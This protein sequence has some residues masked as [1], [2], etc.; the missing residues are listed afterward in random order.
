MLSASRQVSN[1]LTQLQGTHV[2]GGSVVWIVG[3]MEY[4]ESKGMT[5][6]GM[7]PIAAG[8]SS[9]AHHIIVERLMPRIERVP[10]DV[11]NG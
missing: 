4:L 8:V 2:A 10:K 1:P 11:I 7:E 5:P 3:D 6:L 9:D